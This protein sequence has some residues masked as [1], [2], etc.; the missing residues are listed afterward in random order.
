MTETIKTILDRYG[1]PILVC[2]WA[3]YVLRSDVLLPLVEQHSAFI[4]TIGDS[5]KEIADA[6]KEQTKMLYALQP[7]VAEELTKQEQK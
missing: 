4:R 1:L 6:I 2:L 5:Q 7:R 3:G